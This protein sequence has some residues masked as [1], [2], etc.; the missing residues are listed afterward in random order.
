MAYLSD[1]AQKFFEK[2]FQELGK[3]DPN[4]NETWGQVL[5]KAHREEEEAPGG[6]HSHEAVTTI[7]ES[8]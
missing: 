3:L 1:E 6:K 5:V 2:T 7:G 8:K 4:T